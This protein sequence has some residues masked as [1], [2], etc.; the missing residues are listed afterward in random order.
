MRAFKIFSP[1]PI[2]KHPL[3]LVE[4]DQ[5]VP[6]PYEVLIKVLTCGV[7]RTDLHLAEG[8]LK[9]A[10]YPLIPGHQVVGKIVDMGEQVQGFYLNQKVGIAWLGRTCSKCFYCQNGQENLCPNSK[11]TGLH[12]QGGFSEYLTAHAEYIYPLEEKMSDVQIAPLLCAGIIGYRAYLKSKLQKNQKLGLFGFGSSAH[13]MAQLALKQGCSFSVATRDLKH[14]KLA[15]T[16]G[17]QEVT[18]GKK[19]FKDL[20][21]SAII[22]APAGEL[23]PIALQSLRPGGTLALAGIHMSEIPAMEYEPCL[24]HEKHL[25]S[26]EANTREDGKNFLKLALSLPIEPKVEVFPFEKANE[27]LERLKNDAIEGSAVLHIH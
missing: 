15:L 10:Q 3:E 22:F 2:E 13:L 19:P 27:V 7:C 20:V 26:V 12:L 11:Y 25:L 5:P 17:A 16:R 14:Q 24:F 8:D 18:D 9:K 1:K 21:D 23:V 4:I 6:Q